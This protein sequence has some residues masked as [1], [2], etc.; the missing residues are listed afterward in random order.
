MDDIEDRDKLETKIIGRLIKLNP[1]T[2]T[3]LLS[4]AREYDIINLKW[5]K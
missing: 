2:I 5:K 1:N 3:W 4:I